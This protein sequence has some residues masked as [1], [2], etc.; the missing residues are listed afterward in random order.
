MKK[1]FCLSLL[2]CLCLPALAIKEGLD[3]NKYGVI[4]KLVRAKGDTRV[5]TRQGELCLYQRVQERNFRLENNS[6]SAA[7]LLPV[8]KKSTFFVVR[9]NKAEYYI[10]VKGSAF[11]TLINKHGLKESYQI[12]FGDLDLNSLL[13]NKRDQVNDLSCSDNSNI[14]YHLH[15]EGV[16]F[17]VFVNGNMIFTNTDKVDFVEFDLFLPI[18]RFLKSGK[19]SV[20]IG[21]FDSKNGASRINM[22]IF[23]TY[24][25]G[26]ELIPEGTL[27]LNKK[28]IDFSF[29]LPPGTF[30]EGEE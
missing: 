17:N 6:A 27:P 8:I 21:I 2:L 5:M 16:S 7:D 22:S 4:I 14:V 3:F 11:V 15:G 9:A 18:N 10:S 30:L 1:L 28:W 25:G 29:N 26:K 20:K 12:N 19:N 23:D 13:G 24:H